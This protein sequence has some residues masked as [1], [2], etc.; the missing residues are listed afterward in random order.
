MKTFQKTP[1][2]LLENTSL[3]QKRLVNQAFKSCCLIDE[4]LERTNKKLPIE[5][6]IELYLH[7]MGR[8]DKAARGAFAFIES[9][10]Q[11]RIL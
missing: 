5:T 3:D 4:V 6:Y 9:R 1:L 10:Y 2:G 8:R 7:Q 11:L